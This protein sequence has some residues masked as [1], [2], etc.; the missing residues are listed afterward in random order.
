MP[1]IGDVPSSLF[2]EVLNDNQLTSFVSDDEA[3]IS[4]SRREDPDLT[5]NNSK[6]ET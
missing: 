4:T 1:G 3:D 5:Q 6:M 2:E